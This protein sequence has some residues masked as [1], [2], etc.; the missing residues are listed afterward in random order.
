MF[1]TCVTS[2]EDTIV[3]VKLIT[4]PVQPLSVGVTVIVPT[5]SAPLPFGGAIQSAMLP[6]P[7][8]PSPIVVFEFVQLIVAPDGIHEKAPTL[9]C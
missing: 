4:G 7:L 8:V 6:V 5:I 2:S 9:I 3:T 1:W